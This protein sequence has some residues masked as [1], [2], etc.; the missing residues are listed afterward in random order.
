MTRSRS[1][2]PWLQR[3]N[4]TVSQPR[5]MM[6][7]Q[8]TAAVGSLVASVAASACCLLPLLLFTLGAS[9]AWIGALVQLAPLQPYFI[10][11]T[12]ASLGCGYWLVYRSGRIAC[13]GGRTCRRSMPDRLVKSALV[14]STAL[15]VLA[16][17]FNIFM[18][19]LDS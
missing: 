2:P 10:A 5:D 15:V 18:P 11:A 13:A 12:I 16:I 19:L 3:S 9:G 14:L 17:G 7:A 1:R 8:T 4:E 6:R